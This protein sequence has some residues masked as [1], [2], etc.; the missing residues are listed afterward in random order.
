VTPQH[1]GVG[2]YLMKSVL[3]RQFGGDVD[4]RFEADGLRVAITAEI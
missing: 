1:V 3:A 4:L 2:Q